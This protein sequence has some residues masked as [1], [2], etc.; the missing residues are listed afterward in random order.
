MTIE[1][2]FTIENFE[3]AWRRIRNSSITTTKDRL[4]LKV[5]SQALNVHIRN[6]IHDIH[7]DKYIP[8][9]PSILYLPKKSGRLRPFTL[10]S[11]RDRLVYQAIGNILIANTYNH[12]ESKADINVFSPVLAGIDTDYIFY[13]SLRRGDNF[14][15]L[16]LDFRKRKAKGIIRTILSAKFGLQ[17]RKHLF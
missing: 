3:L 13:P 8:Q 14:S 16:R 2:I 6:L 12:L 4:G 5:F 15:N 1:T 17:S 7:E 10:L 9:S 11:M